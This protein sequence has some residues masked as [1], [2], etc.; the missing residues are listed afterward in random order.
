MAYL[1]PKDYQVN[2]QDTNL[3]QIIANDESI[4]QRAQLAGEAE[5]Q[6]YLKQ[7]Y[8]IS[9][10]FQDIEPFNFNKTYLG[11]QR[12]YLDSNNTYNPAATYNT[13]DLVLYTGHVYAARV[14]G[15]TGV[16]TPHDWLDLGPQYSIYSVT[17]PYPEFRYDGVYR[18]GDQVWWKNKTYTCQ[19]PTPIMDHDTALQYGYYQNLPLPNVAPD[20]PTAG[21]QNW[22]TGT[23]YQVTQ[24]LPTNETYY[25][26]T[27]TR[28]AQMVLYC[29]DIVLYHLHTRIS[30]RNI[31]ELRVKRYDDAIAWLQMC[32]KGDITPNLPRLQPLQGNRIR[33]GSAIRQG[34]SY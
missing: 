18:Q 31:P 10:E 2:I 13:N 27:D 1:I 3:Q 11:L 4:R 34:N 7:K 19:K 29:C 33:W 21:L 22:G 16:F 26:E 9:R 15:I 14:D 12:F 8:D 24:E 17:I 23:L 32:A 30:P 20:D 5:A 28:D 25:A 6:S